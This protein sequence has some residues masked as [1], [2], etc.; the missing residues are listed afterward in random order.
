MYG[1]MKITTRNRDVSSN[2]PTNRYGEIVY[3]SNIDINSHADNH[4]FGKEISSCVINRTICPVTAFLGELAPTNNVA[5][6]TSATAII[7]NDGTVF[8]AVLGQGQSYWP[9]QFDSI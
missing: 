5:I 7:D 4:C 3:N 2:N 8:I 6:V 1:N 9:N